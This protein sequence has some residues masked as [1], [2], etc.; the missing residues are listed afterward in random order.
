MSFVDWLAAV[1]L[2]CMILFVIALFAWGWLL[3][4]AKRS[5]SKP[6]KL[7]KTKRLRRSKKRSR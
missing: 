5:G 3:E 4:R 7:P 6:T 2:T 1:G